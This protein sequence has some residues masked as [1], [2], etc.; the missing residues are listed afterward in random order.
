MRVS[1]IIPAYQAA[2]IIAD[3]VRGA[4]SLPAVSEVIV[5]DDGSRDGTGAIAKQAGADRVIVLPTNQGKGAALRAGVGAA[6]GD[7]LLFLDADLGASAAEA[8]AL[9]AAHESDL[10]MVIAVL[11]SPPGTGGFGLLRCLARAAIRLLAGLKV[12]APVSGQRALAAALVRHIGIAPRFGVEVGL[13]VEA[14][15]IGWP[16][17][18]ISLPFEHR[19]TTRRLSGF[20]HRGRQFWDV[21]RLVLQIGYGL[22]WPALPGCRQTLRMTVWA[23][24]LALLVYFARAASPA[25]GMPVM[26]AL[27]ASLALWLPALWLTA[28][29]LRLRKPNYLGRQVP[30]AAGLIAPLVALLILWWAAPAGGVRAAAITVVGV[31]GLVGLLDDLLGSRRQARGLRGHLLALAGGRITTGAVKAFGG[32]A[33]GAAAG[34]MLHP[35]R[36]A[37]VA[38]DALLIALS[39]N[40]INL[41]DLRPGRA[42]KGFA[43]MALLALALAPDSIRLLGPVLA[44]ALVMAPSDFAGRTI[45]GDVGANA[46]GGAAGLA[47]A[48]I[49]GVWGKLAAVL[50]LAVLHLLCE[51]VSLTDVFAR[52]RVLRAL[53]RLGTGGLPPLPTPAGTPP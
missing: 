7:T 28:V 21:L 20:W 6:S 29:W 3:T 35:G 36:P 14:T 17:V 16:I 8:R 43:I 37:E 10:A 39:A 45:M 53:D 34:M 51:R 26:S 38:L 31:M 44:A 48:S 50:V 27:V 5:V 18:E 32:L 4:Q 41:L 24:G 42:L 19:P 40:W 13:T 25:V 2:D 22:G 47:L 15:H 52:N 33:A 30:A 49:L 46:L 9:L 11:P 23:V 1:V 12:Q